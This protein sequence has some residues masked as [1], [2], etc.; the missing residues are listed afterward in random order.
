MKVCSENLT[1]EQESMLGAVHLWPLVESQ[2]VN[3]SQ[4]NNF[5]VFN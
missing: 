5:L 4:Y 3:H 2:V 1:L